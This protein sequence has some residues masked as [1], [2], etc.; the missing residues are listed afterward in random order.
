MKIGP[1]AS[2]FGL[3]DKLTI[4]ESKEAIAL[5]MYDFAGSANYPFF[6]GA[7]IDPEQS[8]PTSSIDA[9][10]DGRLY[11]TAG[12]SGNTGLYRYMHVSIS[13]FSGSL[14]ETATWD[15]AGNV[16]NPKFNMFL[17][18]S[19]FTM[20]CASE[21]FPPLANGNFASGPNYIRLSGKFVATPIKCGRKAVADY[22]EIRNYIGRLRDISL[23]RDDFDGQV[24][25]DEYVG[26][27]LGYT[28][29]SSQTTQSNAILLN[30]S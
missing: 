3:Y 21:K 13:T 25:R 5:T 18:N 4:Y 16:D 24:I 26:K 27:F 17:P 7:I 19:R 14:F 6:A 12:L 30:Y 9:E 22:V 15:L 29:A 1:S 11:G 23:I 8:T 10:V 2:V 28:I 20:P